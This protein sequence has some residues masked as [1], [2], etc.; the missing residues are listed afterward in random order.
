MS[1]QNVL[2][3]GFGEN[4]PDFM[5]KAYAE[6]KKEKNETGRSDILFLKTG[7]THCRILPPHVDSPSWFRE[8]LEHG[9]R[10]EG[11]FRTYTCPTTI[12]DDC[13]ICEIGKEM[14]AK[15]T[16]ESI[17]SAKRYNAKKAFIYNAYV[18]SNPDGKGLKDGMFVLKSGVKVYKQLM[19]FDNDPAGDWG[20][21]SNLTS[22]ID[23]R[24]ERKGTGRFGTEYVCMAV[25]KRSNII[26]RLAAEGHSL[27]MPTDLF[28][29][30]PPV[31]YEILADALA[32]DVAEDE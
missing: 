7:V 17:E 6:S 9:L 18:Y 10:P 28:S 13:P 24:I 31:T 1:D 12:G 21:I 22:G 32:K 29:V 16:E 27:G 15:R 3:P 26:E 11:K 8:Y 25:P 20:D 14:Y 23:F 2:P 19:D 4:D 5:R 30:F